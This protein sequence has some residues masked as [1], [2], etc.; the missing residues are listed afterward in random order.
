MPLAFCCQEKAA[1]DFK[2]KGILWVFLCFFGARSPS[3]KGFWQVVHLNICGCLMLFSGGFR[4]FKVKAHS[5]LSWI[6]LLKSVSE[7]LATW[8]RRRTG[9]NR[10]KPMVQ[11]EKAQIQLASLRP[12]PRD[13][14]EQRRKRLRGKG[15]EVRG[16]G[17]Q[18]RLLSDVL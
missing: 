4:I 13:S 3:F 5:L 17:Q 6:T 1:T 9:L 2:I 12:W 16:T 15:T 11:E 10:G 14:Y 8:E 18:L 7:G